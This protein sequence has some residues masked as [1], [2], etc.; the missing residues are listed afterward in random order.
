MNLLKLAVLVSGRGSNLQA[1]IDGIK[2]GDL[3][4]TISVVISNCQNALALN[5]AREENIPTVF[6]DPKNFFCREDYD[7]L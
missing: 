3:S 6:L 1:I 7:L 2:K 4:A 5:R